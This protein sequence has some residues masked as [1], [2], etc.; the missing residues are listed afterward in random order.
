M[1]RRQFITLRTKN[2]NEEVDLE[3]P[4]DEPIRNLTPLFLKILDWPETEDGDELRYVLTNED[5]RII[6]EEDTFE[7]VGAENFDVIR[8]NLDDRQREAYGQPETGVPAVSPTQP[9]EDEDIETLPA[10]IPFRIPIDGPCLLSEN[11]TMFMIEGKSVKVGRRRKDRETQP[12]IDLSELDKTRIASHMHV[13]LRQEPDGIWLKALKTRNGT[14]L[15]GTIV[16]AGTEA[17][18]KDGDVIRF[19]FRGLSLTFHTP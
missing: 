4:S 8:I 18:L 5:G 1:S 14:L 13:E 6:G 10:P 3:L 9:N 19:G 17:C 11:G 15:N 2:A 7:T 16:E 12:D